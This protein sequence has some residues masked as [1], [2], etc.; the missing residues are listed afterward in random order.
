MPINVRKIFRLGWPKGIKAKVFAAS[1]VSRLRG[2]LHRSQSA[3]VARERMWCKYYKLRASDEFRTMWKEILCDSIG[4]EAC[5]IFYQYVTDKPLILAH[6]KVEG[7]KDKELKLPAPLSY[8]GE[9]ALRY[10]VGAV[11][12]SLKKKLQR[13]AIL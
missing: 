9:N 2:C 8:E 11:L 1:L 13:M 10:T 12:R 4:Q 6:F 5:P 7:E 3:R